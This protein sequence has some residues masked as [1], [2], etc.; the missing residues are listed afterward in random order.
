MNFI[1]PVVCYILSYLLLG[2]PA[3]MF[4]LLIDRPSSRI[5]DSELAAQF[6]IWPLFLGWTVIKTFIFG[7]RCL[8]KF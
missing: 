7:V 5:E 1:L 8:F 6:L 3:F 4:C 2:V